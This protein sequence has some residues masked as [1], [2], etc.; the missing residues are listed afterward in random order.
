[1]THKSPDYS[2]VNEHGMKVSGAAA[3]L[4]EIYTVNGG[5]QNY[6]DTIGKAYIEEFVN[7]HSDIINAGIEATSKRN[8]FKV[9][10]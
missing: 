2:Y 5:L 8:R 7:A 4:H 3:T 9:V 1:M 6:N 10:N